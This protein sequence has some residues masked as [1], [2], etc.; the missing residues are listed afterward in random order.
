MELEIRDYKHTGHYMRI[1][2]RS[3]VYQTQYV[4]MRGQW[5]I[6]ECIGGEWEHIIDEVYPYIDSE[7]RE[8]Q[9]LQAELGLHQLMTVM[10]KQGVTE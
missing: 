4:P 10:F 6:W 7:D 9:M 5:E 3:G 8:N 1:Q 2:Q